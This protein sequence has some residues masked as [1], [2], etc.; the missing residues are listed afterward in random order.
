RPRDQASR[1]AA[2]AAAEGRTPVQAYL[3]PPQPERLRPHGLPPFRGRGILFF[4][5]QSESAD[6]RE[7]GL[8]GLRR[9]LRRRVRTAAAEDHH[10]RAA[11]R[12]DRPLD[13]VR[14]TAAVHRR[15]SRAPQGTLTRVPR[16]T[17]LVG[18]LLEWLARRAAGRC[19]PRDL[20]SRAAREPTWGPLE[21][22]RR[23]AIAGWVPLRRAGRSRSPA[24]MSV[25]RGDWIRTSD[26]LRPRQAGESV[27]SADCRAL[28]GAREAVGPNLG[29]LEWRR[30]EAHGVTRRMITLPRADA[31]RA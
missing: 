25:G 2:R 12:L 29:P 13:G 18:R 10:P 16:W 5:S 24:A 19:S 9:P 11:V 20:R 26:L 8:R 30:A 6:R 7:R 31:R 28:C 14:R 17:R 21:R 23:A 4:G 1:P 3:P 22:Q 27:R 15:S